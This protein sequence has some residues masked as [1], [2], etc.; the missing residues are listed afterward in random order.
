MRLVW[1]LTTDS[2]QRNYYVKDGQFTFCLTTYDDFNTKYV[3][4]FDGKKWIAVNDP[5]II[6]KIIKEVIK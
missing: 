6:K 3:S 4:C 1:T 5:K 2:G